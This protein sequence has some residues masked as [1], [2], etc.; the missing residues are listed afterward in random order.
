MSRYW[1][2]FV[3]AMK[4]M[5]VKYEY[6]LNTRHQAKKNRVILL[7]GFSA[8]QTFSPKHHTKPKIQTKNK[9]T[10]FT[11]AFVRFLVLG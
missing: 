9:L 4:A 11:Y 7:G 8:G 3:L 1:I 2:D 6:S 5:K 10:F